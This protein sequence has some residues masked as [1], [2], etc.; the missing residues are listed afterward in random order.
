MANEPILCPFGCEYKIDD[1]DDNQMMV[2]YPLSNYSSPLYTECVTDVFLKL[3]HIETDHPE[4]GDGPSPFAVIERGD[5]SRD[6]S[7][8]TGDVSGDDEN[9]V[10]CPVAGCGEKLLLTELASHV[11]MHEEEQGAGDEDEEE[12]GSSRSG[13]RLKLDSEIEERGATFDTKLSYALRNLEDVDGKEEKEEGA[14]NAPNGKGKSSAKSVWRDILKMPEPVPGGSP[15]K[16]KGKKR[17]GVSWTLLVSRNQSLTRLKEVRTRPSLE[18][19]ADAALASQA[20]GNFGRPDR[21]GEPAWQRWEDEE[22]EDLYKYGS[23]CCTGCRSSSGTRSIG[24][25]RLSL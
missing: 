12:E 16:G 8:G 4:D 6:S 22:G 1:G 14:T 5:P 3:L 2:C 10:K 21:D 15:G 18:R 17:L 25:L 13:K 24:G 19:K 23:W 9:W 7:T 20:T 11:E